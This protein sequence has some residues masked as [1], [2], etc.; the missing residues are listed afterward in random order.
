MKMKFYPLVVLTLVLFS[1]SSMNTR[2][3][4]IEE[5][6][7]TGNAQKLSSY[8]A[9]TITLAVPG[10]KGN[11]SS[12]Q[13]RSIM[14][15]FFRS[16]PPKSFTVKSSGT[17]SRSTQFYLGTYVSTHQKS[18]AVYVLFDSDSANG[19]ITQITFETN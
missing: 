17:T 18:Y 16:N 2:W 5:S 14:H 1:F 8:F 3:Q 9:T 15:D 7:S 4:S 13:A 6:I 12:K 10:H 19:L 11:F